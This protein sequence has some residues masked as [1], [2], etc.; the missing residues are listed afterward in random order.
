MNEHL[1]NIDAPL[2][3]KIG[4]AALDEPE[5]FGQRCSSLEPDFETRAVESPQ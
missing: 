5:A 4:G 3:V 2:V 1:L